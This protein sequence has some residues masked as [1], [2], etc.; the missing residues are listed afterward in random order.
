MCEKSC[1]GSAAEFA[2]LAPVLEKYGGMKGSLITILQK[3][4]DI[5]GYLSL[6]AINHI[7]SKTGSNPRRS[8]ASPHSTRS[9]G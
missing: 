3:T 5:Y 7:A 1:K 4:Q 6:D 9:S 2:A 8:T